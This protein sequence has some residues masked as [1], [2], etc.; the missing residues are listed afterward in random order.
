MKKKSG[1]M[2]LLA[3][4][5]ALIGVAVAVAVFMQKAGRRLK[6]DMGYNGEL[7]FEDDMIDEG[8]ES[9][10]AESESGDASAPD[11]AE[12]ASD[13]DEIEE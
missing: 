5:T 9:F 2:I 12:T 6:K 10:P 4:V 1:W 8:I 3:A 11:A 13:G 7:Y